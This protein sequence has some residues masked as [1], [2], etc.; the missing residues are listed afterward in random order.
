MSLAMSLFCFCQT[1]WDTFALYP[2]FFWY[3]L[4]GSAFVSCF[5]CV[6]EIYEPRFAGTATGALNIF[7]FSG[8]AFYQYVM[9]VAINSYTPVSSG[10]Y[11]LATYQ[12]TFLIP[13]V[14]LIVGIIAIAFFKEEKVTK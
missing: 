8:G 9:G 7:L 2:L 14:G 13:V 3:G 12:A 10:V 4:T 11:S 6:K 1:N 5:A